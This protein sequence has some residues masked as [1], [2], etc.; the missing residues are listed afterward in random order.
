MTLNSR[1]RSVDQL[2]KR[3]I[4]SDRQYGS[5][6]HEL[7]RRTLPSRDLKAE[8][9][10]HPCIKNVLT[11]PAPEEYQYLMAEYA[12]LVVT[13][14]LVPSYEWLSMRAVMSANQRVSMIYSPAPARH[15]SH[16]LL[17]GGFEQL[18]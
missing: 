13:P 15:V 10:I 16:S 1:G 8:H 14:A 6:N 12:R 11:L 17:Q 9:L 2:W 5:G 7:E 4:W 3:E 18:T